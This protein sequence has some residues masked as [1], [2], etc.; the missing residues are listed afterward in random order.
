MEKIRSEIRSTEHGV[1]VIYRRLSDYLAKKLKNTPLTPNQATL[2][3]NIFA[4]SSLLILIFLGRDMLWRVLFAVLVQLST[5]FDFLDGSLAREKDM[6]TKFGSW[7]DCI[8]DRLFW[9]ASLLTII[10]I[11]YQS[12]PE[13]KVIIL[14]F[15]TLSFTALIQLY[16]L[17]FQRDYGEILIGTIKYIKT[18]SKLGRIAKHFFYTESS[19]LLLVSLFVLADQF[20]LLL[21]VLAIYS[22]AFLIAEILYLTKVLIKY[23]RRL[24]IVE[25]PQQ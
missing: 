16:N 3:S 24:K 8:G 14:G 13:L 25:K 19:Y 10:Y 4:L 18:E 22:G 7:V 15:L 5:I 12:H 1:K 2:I 21:W 9:A 20:Y 11:T 17:Y 23:D 6:K